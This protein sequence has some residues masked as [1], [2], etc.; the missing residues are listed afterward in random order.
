MQ[1]EQ[2]RRKKYKNGLVINGKFYDLKT[3]Y[4]QRPW[5][6]EAFLLEANK[7]FYTKL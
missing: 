7:L 5:E 4:N 2:G 6:Q 1:T 3:S